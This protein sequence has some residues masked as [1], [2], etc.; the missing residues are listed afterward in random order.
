MDSIFRNEERQL[1]TV[2]RPRPVEAER[3]KTE[4]DEDR[5]RVIGAIIMALDR[6]PEAREP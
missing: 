6:F 5:D 1:R 2:L 4:T 3:R